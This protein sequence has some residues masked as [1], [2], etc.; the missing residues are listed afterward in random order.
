[1]CPELIACM[2]T[3]RYGLCLWSSENER[4]RASQDR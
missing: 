1:M 2:M 4:E 3:I